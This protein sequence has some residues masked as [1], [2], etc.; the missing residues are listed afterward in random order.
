MKVTIIHRPSGEKEEVEIPDSSTILAALRAA[1]IPP[2]VTICMVN[3]GPVPVDTILKDG[4]RFE[5][6]TVVSGG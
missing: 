6:V 2:D 1:D 5:A 3:G 4:D